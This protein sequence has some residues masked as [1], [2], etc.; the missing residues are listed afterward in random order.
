MR[1]APT[2]ASWSYANEAQH[3]AAQ[4]K[5]EASDALPEAPGARVQS[6]CRLHGP[7]L[8]LLGAGT[9]HMSNRHPP[10]RWHGI[11]G[12]RREGSASV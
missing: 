3:E 2:D 8:F 4:F 9:E 12:T 11:T 10:A 7:L 5:I 1:T 6:V